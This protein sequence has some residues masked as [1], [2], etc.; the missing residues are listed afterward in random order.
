LRAVRGLGLLVIVL[1]LSGAAALLADYW[2]DLPAA[3]RQVLFSG[4]L[5]GGAGLLLLGVVVPLC[6]RLDTVALAAVVEQ[7]YPELAERL[8]SAVEL[9]ETSVEGH[10][11][12][13][14]IA[15]LMDETEKQSTRLDFRP[16]VPLRRAGAAAALT[17]VVALLIVAP[18]FVWPQQYADLMKRFF[19]P[20]N[21]AAAVPYTPEVRP[22]VIPV[23]LAVDSPRITVTPPEYARKVQDEETFHGL[24]ALSALRHSEVRFD[25][26]FTRPAVAAYLEWISPTSAEI[27]RHSLTLSEDRQAASFVMPATA[28]GAYRVVLEAE[29]DIRT[30]LQGGTIHVRPDR[31]PAVVKFTGKEDLRAV[32]PYERIPL[33]IEAADDIA[34]AGI[35]LEY[36]VNDGEVVRQPIA[37]QGGDT[38]SAAA[39]YV[40]ELG[41][42]VKPDDQVSYRFRVRDNL[43]KEYKGPHVIVYPADRWLTLRVV[44]HGDPLKQKEILA[45]RDEINRQLE[46]I[47][48]SLLR[49]KRGVDK[50][51]QET[52][53]QASLPPEEAEHVQ[54]LQQD[55][56]GSQKALRDMAGAVEA[57]PALQSIAELARAV[58][59]RE[60]HESQKALELAPRQPSPP[61]RSSAFAK[62]DEQLASAV[63][64]L[65][66][67]KKTN[68]KL[69]QE[70]LDQAKLEMLADREIQL[71]EQVAELAAKH[72]V[73]D[74]TAK[75]L[76]EKVQREQAEVAA[77][78]ERMAQ[79]SEP[80]K[81]ALEQGRA[82]E[83][84]Q[85]AE[86]ARE[87]AQAQRDLAKAEAETERQRHSD[88]LAEL[89]RKQQEL[90]EKE[91]ELA[92]ETR[93]AAEAAK[94]S[95]LKAEE[96]QQAA[97]ALKQGDAQGAVK[98]QDQAARDLDRLVR[99]FERAAKG[100]A[101]LKEAARQL[102]RQ[103]REL[104]DTVQ[105][106]SQAA[107]AERPVVPDN[108]VGELARKQAEI[109]KQAAELVRNVGQEQGEKSSLAQQSRQAQQAARQTARQIQAG[110][111]SQAHAAGRQTAEQM[112]QLATQLART[113]RGNDP[114]TPDTLQLARQ[115]GRQQEEINRRLQSL[116]SDARAQLGQQQARQRDLQ[117]DTS[118]LAQQLGRMAREART[119]GPVQSALQRAAGASQ[120]AQDA[121]RQAQS[122]AQQGQPEAE[123]QSQERAAQLLTQAARDAD[124]AGRRPQQA[125]SKS[126]EA[127]VQ[128]RQQ[129]IR[130]GGQLNQGQPAQARSSMKQ[131]AQSLAHAAREMS[132][133][134]KQ[135]GKPGQ[136]GQPS[137]LGR[138]PGGLPDLSEFG[139]DK[140]AYA[141]KS[142]GELPGELRTKITQAM[143]SRYG[144]DYARTIKY[145][146]EQIAD[147]KK[148]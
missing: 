27:A 1:G 36:R 133:N 51:R 39:R 32:L 40:L 129:M 138:A 34:V 42:K 54:Q 35:E 99:D 121:M 128:A 64:K 113:P 48:E 136:S 134:P 132:A 143:K 38:P 147:T 75:P 17:A 25:F 140:A 6:R 77:E 8:T 63:K 30:V 14:L 21:V 49:E 146:F 10:G 4:W 100:S 74:P 13:V 58:A 116:A 110:A 71:A 118:K 120:Q 125:S 23:E 88:R 12:P 91:V 60:M 93:Q 69:A 112:R 101:D 70:R 94:T 72:P 123:R 124:Q 83:S 15:L 96:T 16:A 108:P 114:K 73:L 50:V 28:E 89:A 127:V 11:S 76:A 41:G 31:P 5:C 82:E 79:Q 20:W 78:L 66:E 19:R 141:D 62:A 135:S 81:Q 87:L 55:N 95:P 44:R 105:R 7:K 68:D 52:R 59:D 3:T 102:A 144:E 18:A 119:S 130:A 104:R 148:K 109:A 97:D 33:E 43:P 90:A 56:R 61:E 139:L 37:L 67:L 103:Q 98:H 9:A 137:G 126:G 142:W 57:T 26:S 45:Q 106:A 115:L 2:L 46:S 122:Q 117:Q 84:R 92:R 86:R 80:L 29:Y 85:L 47:K 107:R 111:L 131:A 24:V 145:Y 22:A 65:D 53:E